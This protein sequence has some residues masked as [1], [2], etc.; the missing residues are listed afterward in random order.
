M[1]NNYFKIL[2]VL[3]LGVSL[4]AFG[5]IQL[6]EIADKVINT[7]DIDEN[8]C[9]PIVMDYL[10][11]Y[12]TQAGLY[13]ASPDVIYAEGSYAYTHTP[14]PGTEFE[15][16]QTL[17]EI[18]LKKFVKSTSFP[19]LPYWKTMDYE[20]FTMTV[21]DNTPPT[22]VNEPYI[23][24]L[25][26]DIGKCTA[27][28]PDLVYGDYSSLNGFFT[29]NSIECTG[30][31]DVV[32]QSPA[33]GSPLAIGWNNISI[34][35][36]DFPG[37]NE[38]TESF[39][40]WVEDLE[41]PMMT[42]IP[43]QFIPAT[44]EDRRGCYVPMPDVS[45]LVLLNSEDECSG[46]GL[47][48]QDPAIGTRIYFGGDYDVDVTVADG[49][50]NTSAQSF[51]MTV[52]DKTAPIISEKQPGHGPFYVSETH[53]I[54]RWRDLVEIDENCDNGLT[55][56]LHKE[57]G[58]MRPILW[59]DCCELGANPV[60]ITATDD[61]GNS[62]ELTVEVLIFDNIAPIIMHRGG[63]YTLPTTETTDMCEAMIPDLRGEINGL[64]TD[65]CDECSPAD[66]RYVQEYRT[67]F[68]PWME[69][70]EGTLI[71]AT[72]VNQVALSAK[73]KVGNLSDRVI[74]NIIIEDVTGPVLAV[75]DFTIQLD[76][77]G[78]AE[79][80]ITDV[81][82]RDNS[83]DNCSH[84]AESAVYIEGEWYDPN[85]YFHTFDCDDIGVNPLEIKVRDL[86]GNISNTAVV[87]ITVEDNISPDLSTHNYTLNIDENGEGT[88]TPL[89]FVYHFPSSAWGVTDNCTASADIDLKIA[90]GGHH[91]YPDA[92]DSSLWFDFIDYTCADFGMYYIWVKATDEQGNLT[93]KR[94]NLKVQ[95]VMNPLI[96]GQ[97]VVLQMGA[98]GLVNLNV[99]QIENGSTDNCD[100]ELTYMMT[101]VNGHPTDMED[102]SNG[103]QDYLFSTCYDDGHSELYYASMALAKKNQL[104][105]Y[106]CC[107]GLGEHDVEFT[108][109]D[110][111]DNR[112]S[113]TV[114]VTI[115]EHIIARTIESITMLIPNDGL[116][117]VSDINDNSTDCFGD[118]LYT[119]FRV[120][121][122]V[123]EEP[124]ATESLTLRCD[125]FQW[126]EEGN[127]IG[128]EVMLRVQE[129]H[130]NG[131]ISYDAC[132]VYF[133]DVIAPVAMSVE[134]FNLQLD[135]NNE[136]TLTP[137]DIDN[138]S[139][140]NSGC[141][142]K[143]I[144]FK[145]D[146]QVMTSSI[147][148][149]QVMIGEDL[150]V[151]LKVVDKVGFTDYSTTLVHVFGTTDPAL[152]A[153]AL[154]IAEFTVYPN[155]TTDMLF[156]SNP[157]ETS[158]HV[159]LFNLTGKLLQEKYSVESMI[160]I[161]MMRHDKGLYFIQFI[162]DNNKIVTK[163]IIKK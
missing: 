101:K 35:I 19:F 93:V 44:L 26:T 124:T 157:Y 139:Y 41:G 9:S 51:K 2:L 76:N 73:D 117:Y 3:L 77:N 85:Y 53:A 95:D 127:P 69:W 72:D 30:Y 149:T 59:F 151:V 120:D 103:V 119:I 74:F 116:L 14:Q 123:D 91:S 98:D 97:D 141:L 5:Q 37:G 161:D 23:A 134:E 111:S 162:S 7:E 31:V 92:N 140:D 154:E 147:D 80:V 67:N 42:T 86:A 52:T 50:G 10:A 29:D 4:T 55:V 18:T 126:D 62:S 133:E 27:S 160:E 63:D 46:L 54:V 118:N 25:A 145:G 96:E 146:G 15:I 20:S 104:E 17:V 105:D 159:Q 132:I 88:V 163:K 24:A 39:R 6:P 68:G 87:N 155:P 36:R 32:A 128:L 152:N 83:Y 65:N 70:I 109:V 47:V 138:G 114:K 130:P 108:V 122:A 129:N 115:L 40:V 13:D 33:A 57:D 148:F 58:M 137:D 131:E 143:Y 106:D 34:T 136:A 16:G 12:T 71:Y 60:T 11:G 100:G 121:S 49:K 135:S 102:L 110:E 150:E 64:V 84:I 94:A 38:I 158:M 156:I 56:T 125:D 66:Y 99:M 82:D 48:T 142:T 78:H 75:N 43:H 153:G 113:M 112:S 79:L 45:Q 28:M 107:K 81:I 90:E 21:V 1:K 144:Y 22:K 8:D 89:N 61:S